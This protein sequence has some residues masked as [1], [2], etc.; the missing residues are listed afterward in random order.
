V[1]V[2]DF[3]I[4]FWEAEF[5]EYAPDVNTVVYVGGNEARENI[6]RFELNKKHPKAQ[7]VLTTF[8]VANSVSSRSLGL[9]SA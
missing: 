7:V 8:E 3:E 1:V 4:Q 5:S 2:P 9:L 6:Q